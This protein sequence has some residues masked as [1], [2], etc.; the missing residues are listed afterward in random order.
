MPCFGTHVWPAAAHHR[1]HGL[2]HQ[3]QTIPALLPSS[4]ALQ[5]G[6]SLAINYMAYETMR[7]VWLA[8]TDRQT[9][10]V[11]ALSA[12]LGGAL[13]QAGG[14]IV[15]VSSLLQGHGVGAR[16]PQFAVLAVPAWTLC[17]RAT[18]RCH[19]HPAFCSCSARPTG[20]HEL[21]VWQRSR[22]SVLNSHL[23]PGFGAAEAAAARPRWQQRG[24]G[25]GRR[26]QCGACG[27]LPQRAERRGAG[28]G[29][30]IN[31]YPLFACM[32]AVHGCGVVGM[33]QR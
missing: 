17:N 9:P 16:V 2:H 24:G 19:G 13:G 22:P 26:Q 5:V 21:G 23:P 4:P 1:M 14:V 29:L 6:P 12:L 33:L 32:S 25:G 11:R 31:Y 8:R 3:V 20:G 28:A 30:L 10:T 7:S 18:L 27:N 15:V